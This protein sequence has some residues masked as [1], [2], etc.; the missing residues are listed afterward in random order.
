[1]NVPTTYEMDGLFTEEDIDNRYTVVFQCLDCKKWTQHENWVTDENN[2]HIPCVH[3]GTTSYDGSSIKSLR[4]YNP[5]TD[6][7]RRPKAQ[8]KK[9]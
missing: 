6:N 3:C 9:R 1:M 7:K 8:K 4:T 2:T 5:L